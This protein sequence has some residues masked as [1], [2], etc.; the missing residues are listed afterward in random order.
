MSSF[1]CRKALDLPSAG[2]ATT[3]AHFVCSAHFL[4]VVLI[5]FS[6]FFFFALRTTVHV[7][8]DAA[9]LSKL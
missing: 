4:P 9:P 7:S 3:A 8:N 1:Y 5:L 2:L 6:L